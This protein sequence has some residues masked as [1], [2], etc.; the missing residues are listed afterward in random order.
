MHALSSEAVFAFLQAEG[1]PE[2][3]A[4]ARLECSACIPQIPASFYSRTFQNPRPC[5]PPLQVRHARGMSEAC[6][7]WSLLDSMM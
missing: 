5:L 2:L 4:R 6:Q 1:L 3:I 7:H